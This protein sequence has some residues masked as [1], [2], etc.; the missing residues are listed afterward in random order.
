MPGQFVRFAAPVFVNPALFDEAASQAE[1]QQEQRLRISR[2]RS[3]YLM[4]MA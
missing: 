2:I 3:H 4:Q 1:Q